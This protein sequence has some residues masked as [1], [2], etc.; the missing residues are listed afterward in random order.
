MKTSLK[1]IL[2][3]L[4]FSISSTANGQSQGDTTNK[5]IKLS[6]RIGLTIANHK[7]KIENGSTE[8]GRKAILGF[9]AGVGITKSIKNNLSLESGLY[10]VQ[11]GSK[12]SEEGISDGDEFFSYSDILRMLY[13]DVPILLRYRLNKEDE[14][15]FAFYGG[16]Q[17]SFLLNARRNSKE[18][19]SQSNESVT[20]FFKIFDAAA[21]IGV[22]Y[23]FNNGFGINAAYDYGFININKNS[24]HNGLNYFKTY[25][26]VFKV[27]IIYQ[28]NR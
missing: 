18:A 27:S 5:K 10:L 19:N 28:L 22:G 2:S 6:P 23:L 24:D 13:I 7:E 12:S 14:N 16:V 11:K 15:S 1:I 8:S 3:C 25:N 26:R 9:K 21:S 17:P 20:D 4:I